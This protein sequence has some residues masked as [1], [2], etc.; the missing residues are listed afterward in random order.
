MN[1]N[2]RNS[3]EKSGPIKGLFLRVGGNMKNDGTILTG[4]DATI[5]IAVGGDY[6]SKKGKIIQGHDRPGI[7]KWHERFLWKF[8]ISILIVIVGGLIVGG[9]LYFLGWV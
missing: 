8:V 1:Q 9:I 3:E 7:K 2:N 6:S 4:A 5:D